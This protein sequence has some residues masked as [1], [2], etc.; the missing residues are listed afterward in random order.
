MQARRTNHNI[1]KPSAAPTFGVTISSPE[2]T[3]AALMMRPG[4]R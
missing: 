1:E 4:P 2:P 3:M